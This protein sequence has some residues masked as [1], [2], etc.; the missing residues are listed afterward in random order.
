MNVEAGALLK[1]SAGFSLFRQSQP[2]A[3]AERLVFFRSRRL[4]HFECGVPVEVR[5]LMSKPLAAA[6]LAGVK[7][8]QKKLQKKYKTQR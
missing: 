2:L 4:A 5:W 7:H 8:R 3:E 1:K 6:A